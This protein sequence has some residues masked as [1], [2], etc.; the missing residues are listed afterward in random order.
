MSQIGL[1]NWLSFCPTFNLR[2]NDEELTLEASGL[3][4]SYG[5]ISTLVNSFDVKLL[6]F[7]FLSTAPHFFKK[8]NLSVLSCNS[9][10]MMY[11]AV[12]T[13]ECVGEILKH[14]IL[15]QG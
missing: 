10:I 13:F 9:V 2:A 8:L 1:S 3:L 5:G 4:C 7:T 11:R 14:D 6:C 12:L 15:N